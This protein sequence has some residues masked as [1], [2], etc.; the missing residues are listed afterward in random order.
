MRLFH[1]NSRCQLSGSRDTIPVCEPPQ[2]AVA[3]RRPSPR[4]SALGGTDSATVPL[5]HTLHHSVRASLSSRMLRV[6][7][8][9]SSRSWTTQATPSPPD[10]LPTVLG[11]P[12]RLMCAYRRPVAQSTHH[13]RASHL[14]FSPAS[15]YRPLLFL[16]LTRSA[17]SCPRL[18]CPRPRRLAGRAQ[19]SH[20]WARAEA[21]RACTTSHRAAC[22][23]DGRA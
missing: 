2:T 14:L 5:S 21:H 15:S 16:P 18:V 20:A 11:V 22:T 6:V 1:V 7:R 3:A 19:R 10:R 17:P 13:S 8:R 12:S 9:S 23:L 4:T